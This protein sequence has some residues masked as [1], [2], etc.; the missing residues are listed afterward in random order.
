MKSPHGWASVPMIAGAPLAAGPMRGPYGRGSTAGCRDAGV[1]HAVRT[2]AETAG[3]DLAQQA[4]RV[5]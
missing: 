3:V 2:C 1:S 5:H 4:R